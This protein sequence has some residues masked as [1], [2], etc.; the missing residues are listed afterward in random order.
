MT[1]TSTTALLS[2]IYGLVG[3]ALVYMTPTCLLAV[4]LLD[5]LVYPRLLTSQ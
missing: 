1:D 2:W 4:Y 3:L 5:Q